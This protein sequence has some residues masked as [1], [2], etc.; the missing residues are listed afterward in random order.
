ME[1]RAR[2]CVAIDLTR[3]I[4]MEGLAKDCVL[5]SFLAALPSLVNLN[6]PQ[7]R[8]SFPVWFP[9]SRLLL[10]AYL[11]DLRFLVATTMAASLCRILF[12]ADIAVGFL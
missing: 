1:V 2:N 7:H 4:A 3:M 6:S 12:E 8:S 11:P 10:A 5:E 9:K